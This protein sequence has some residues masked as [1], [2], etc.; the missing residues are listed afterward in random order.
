V[1]TITRKKTQVKTRIHV[2][3]AVFGP[4]SMCKSD[5][6]MTKEYFHL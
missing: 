4:T 5:C 6:L 2:W 1:R 3:S